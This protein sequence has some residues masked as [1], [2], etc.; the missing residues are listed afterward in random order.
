M[1]HAVG[2]FLS[3]SHGVPHGT[4]CA[5]FL[6]DFLAYNQEADSPYSDSFY[7]EIGCSREELVSLL[8]ELTPVFSISMTEE[9]IAGLHDRWTDNASIKKIRG[10][11]TADM[12]DEML[13]RKYL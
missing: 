10:E 7:R 12:I 11:M 9:E 8:Q 3:E 6:P 5:Q 2:Y 4:A 13:R 1:P